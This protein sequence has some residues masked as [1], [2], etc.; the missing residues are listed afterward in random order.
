M[1]EIQDVAWGGDFS[2]QCVLIEFA[3]PN[4]GVIYICIEETSITRI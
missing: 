4:L 1:L 3:V 2:L